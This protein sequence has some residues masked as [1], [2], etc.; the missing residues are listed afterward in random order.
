MEWKAAFLNCTI[1]CTMVFGYCAVCGLLHLEQAC[2]TV[3]GL[4]PAGVC[5]AGVQ[6]GNCEGRC[7]VLS[8]KYK[9]YKENPYISE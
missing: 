2:S 7:C 5:A 8:A 6:A 3:G 4:P 9:K 1:L